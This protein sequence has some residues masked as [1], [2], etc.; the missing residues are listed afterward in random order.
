MSLTA[1]TRLG[2]YEIRSKIGE[3][4]M[5]E[6]YLAHDTELDRKVALKILPAEVAAN[7]DRM[8]RFVQEAKAA[9]ALNHS[10]I[11]HIYEIGESE[12]THFIAMEFIDGEILRHRILEPSMKLSEVLDLAI[13]CAS[14][15]AAAHLAG[16]AH[17][18]IKPEN[19]MVRHDGIVK[20]LDF[21][22]AKLVSSE[23]AGIDSEAATK[24]KTDPGTIMGTPVY[25]SP[26]QAR[27]KATD[28]RADVF[29]LGVVLYEMIAGCLPFEGSTSAEIV[30]SILSETEPQPLA[31]YS[32]DVP[33][34]LERIVSKALRKNRDERYQTI[35]DLLLDLKSL[36]QEL[37][38]EK[39]LERSLQSPSGSVSAPATGPR[40]A[41]LSAAT[42]TV[43]DTRTT[44]ISTANRR[45]AIIVVV[46]LLI[47]ALTAG[48]YFYSTRSSRG[49]INSIAV[50]PF[51]NTSNSGELDYLSE[52][53]SES[54][55][56][57]LSKLPDL[58]VI[59]RGSSFKFKG[60]DSEPQE[61]A[62]ARGVAAILSGKV[63]QR[64]DNL[65]ITAALVNA[66]D[67]R[68]IWGEQYNRPATDLLAVQAEI[69]REIAE[70][71]RSRLTAG[72]REDVAK[73]ETVNPQAYQLMLKGRYLA[74]KGGMENRRK[75]IESLSEAIA[76]DPDYAF[77]YAALS[78]RYVS[79][80]DTSGGDPQ[81][82]LR[83]AE[84]AAQKA[85]QL[86]ANLDE[87]HYALALFKPDVWDWAGAEREY[88][89][90]L[91]LN[92]SLARAHVGYAQ[93]LSLTGQHDQAL[94]EV[95]RARDLDPLSPVI[96]ARVGDILCAARRYDQAIEVLRRLLEIDQSFAGAYVPLGFSYTGKEMYREAIAAYEEAI[97]RGEDSTDRQIDLG[98]VYAKSG[99]RNR[100]QEILKQLETS[101]KYVSPCE[102]AILYDS[103]GEREQ[104]FASLEKAYAAHDLKLKGLLDPAYDGLRGDPRFANLLNRV[105]LNQTA[106]L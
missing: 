50:L 85:L 16:I 32:R 9:A 91:E 103:L 40:T 90:A 73:R 70:K 1:G 104:A 33:P 96:S 72:E 28:A 46:P 12:G 2:R 100:A 5:G 3:G 84:A 41:E 23:I 102:L 14:A 98:A 81:D 64:G 63:I 97:K 55:I 15:L 62:K 69:S 66:S 38:F 35:Q 89:R 68:Q 95:N 71:L 30:A 101:D 54:L 7:Q 19:I 43:D 58:K 4:G 6:V 22:L 51:A 42:S 87:A 99:D 18:D 74:R 13:Q 79:L 31:R 105:G 57:S 53:I 59:A 20:V 27:G 34:E 94:A 78:V 80:A 86:D 49:A 77:A 60:K 24:F 88:K 11:A 17:R 47:I 29:S 25:M 52:G 10:N 48:L 65:V 93:L 82:L 83:R 106:K 26:E 75:A 45:R 61:V 92:P 37:E 56:N 8:R 39:K 76:L 44:G 67:N 21:G 36:K